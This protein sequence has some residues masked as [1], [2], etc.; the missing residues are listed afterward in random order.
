MLVLSDLSNQ[1]TPLIGLYIHEAFTFCSF[2][3][4][5]LQDG[6]EESSLSILRGGF[7]STD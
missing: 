2:L 6:C 4:T 7:K 1:N 3:S 5:S